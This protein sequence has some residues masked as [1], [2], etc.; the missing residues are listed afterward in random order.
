M[1]ADVTGRRSAIGGSTAL[2]RESPC[3]ASLPGGGRLRPGWRPAASM[4]RDL[5]PR[6]RW[7]L[8]QYGTYGCR[9]SSSSS[10]VPKTSSSASSSLDGAVD[11]RPRVVHG[12]AVDHL[13]RTR[14]RFPVDDQVLSG[15][16][17]RAFG[18]HAAQVVP[19]GQRLERHSV[20]WV[21][22]FA[23][24]ELRGFVHACWDGGAHDFLLDTVVEPTHQRRGIGRHLVRTLVQ[25]V[26][27]AGCEWLHVDYEPHLSPFYRDACGFGATDAG[28][29]PLSR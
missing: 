5:W 26:A 17:A 8:S 21:G 9:S 25:E 11:R 15:L 20:T 10:A 2:M 24:D 6:N 16:H 13:L 3:T 29:L 1:L 12:G 7:S 23:L 14:V 27:A 18:G 28:L 22:A 4:T 19:W